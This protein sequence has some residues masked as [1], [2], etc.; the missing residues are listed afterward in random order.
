MKLPRLIEIYQTLTPH[1]VADLGEVYAADAH[2]RDPFNEVQGLPAIQQIFH[3]MFSQVAE[4]RFVVLEQVVDAP[5]AF[6][7]W[8]FHFRRGGQHWTIRGCSHLKFNA[9]GKVVAHRD[10]WDAAE[11]LYAHLPL[12]GG[13]LR[14][15]QRRLSAT[16]VPPFK[17]RQ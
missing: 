8:D 3:H 15:L 12:L 7:V 17:K 6:L 5:A 14:W 11:E 1:T 2:F 9:A 13:V 4:P 16:T 10:Y